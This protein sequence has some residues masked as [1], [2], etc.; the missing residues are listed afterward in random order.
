MPR[1]SNE[2]K[3]N[4]PRKGR[5]NWREYLVQA[6]I[7]NYN[8]LPEPDSSMLK[9][10]IDDMG[11]VSYEGMLTEQL[12]SE[13]KGDNKESWIVEVVWDKDYILWKVHDLFVKIGLVVNGQANEKRW[14]TFLNP[15]NGLIINYA[16][17]E[18]LRK[19]EE[20][21]MQ[22]AVSQ[23]Q[24]FPGTDIGD[25]LEMA[26][27]AREKSSHS[28]SGNGTKTSDSGNGA[29]KTTKASKSKV[30]S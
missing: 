26:K 15:V 16:A 18:G 4:L 9:V 19:Q 17:T 8:F 7:R 2:V 13:G 21:D 29:T 6:D 3:Q 10:N 24:R 30:V 25:W 28:D 5:M 14:D 1:L 12:M 23:V 27:K 11:D 20:E 22:W